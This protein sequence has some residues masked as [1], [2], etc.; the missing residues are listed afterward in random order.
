MKKF[1]LVLAACLFAALLIT[2]AAVY[3]DSPQEQPE[4]EFVYA[5]GVFELEE[6]G[7]DFDKFLTAFSGEYPETEEYKDRTA[8]SEGEHNA[9]RFLAQIFSDA[10]LKTADGEDAQTQEDY[11]QRFTLGTAHSYNVVAVKPAHDTD[12]NVIIGAHYDNVYGVKRT[13]PYINDDR[14]IKSHGAYDNGSGVAAMLAVADNLKDADLPF[15]V[16][17]IAFGAEEKGMLGSKHYVENVLSQSQKENILLMVNL[18]CISA[19][20]Y[21]Y[22]FCMDWQSGHEDF[23][24]QQAQSLEGFDGL[25]LRA[26]PLNKKFISDPFGGAAYSHYG[27]LSDNYYFVRENIPSAF[28]MSMNFE[29][30]KKAGVVESDGHNDIMHTQ[31]DNFA[32][33]KQLY[34]ETYLKHMQYVSRL[35][36]DT[37]KHPEF[38]SAMRQSR[39]NT[40]TYNFITNGKTL[41][42]MAFS[43][44]LIFAVSAFFYY[45]KIKKT[46]EASI[47]EFLSSPENIE[48]MNKLFKDLEKTP[49]DDIIKPPKKQK[50]SVFGEEFE[51]KDDDDDGGGNK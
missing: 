16:T 13:N 11:L 51:N 1:C 27:Y 31:D 38:V 47:K 50:F 35:V 15:N 9:A 8:G 30:L 22:L 49:F 42:I 44:W 14:A 43:V 21:L 34:P 39:A 36:S 25:A 7:F 18:D 28:F 23:I 46:A 5:D 3:A 32:K 48:R 29:S 37:L 12:L 20:D 40:P 17:F 24:R 41:I 10:Q 26:L 2:P 4:P 33:I 19:G 6:G 45:A